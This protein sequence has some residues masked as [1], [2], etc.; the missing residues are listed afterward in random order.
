MTNVPNGV[1]ILR[2]ISIASNGRTDDD[3]AK[4]VCQRA[5]KNR[6]KSALKCS[7]M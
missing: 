6:F 1:E 7:K 5:L 4:K 2:K 3:M